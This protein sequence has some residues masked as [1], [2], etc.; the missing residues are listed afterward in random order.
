[1]APLNISTARGTST[2]ATKSLQLVGDQG[3]SSLQS[4][5]QPCQAIVDKCE[6]LSQNT[7]N[8]S[9]LR[10]GENTMEVRDNLSVTQI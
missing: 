2:F 10:L 9:H 6:G 7:A 1:M 3:I 5:Y 8:R 4:P